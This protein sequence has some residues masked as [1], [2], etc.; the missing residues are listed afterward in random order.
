MQSG[1]QLLSAPSLPKIRSAPVSSSPGNNLAGERLSRDQFLS[2]QEVTP[3]ILFDLFADPRLRAAANARQRLQ[4]AAPN[5][6]LPD[7]Q[8]SSQDEGHA[9]PEEI[10]LRQPFGAC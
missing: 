10:A 5:F 9:S 7:S 8:L 6:G 2:S 4:V 3:R 1:S